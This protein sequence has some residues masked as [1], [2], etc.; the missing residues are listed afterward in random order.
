MK[1]INFLYFFGSFLHSWIRIANQDPD[2]DPGIPLNPDP[3]HCMYGTFLYCT[4][5]VFCRSRLIARL[6][7]VRST[8]AYKAK[9][10][11]AF[12]SV[13]YRSDHFYFPLR[14]RYCTY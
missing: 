11:T 13:A 4:V 10:P 8:L 12:R 1:I 7:K 6:I 5:L 2:T 3:Q 14:R 9:I